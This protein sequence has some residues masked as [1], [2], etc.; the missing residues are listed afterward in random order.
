MNYKIVFNIPN[1]KYPTEVLVSEEQMKNIEPILNDKKVIQIDGN[2]YS[3][4][5][6]AKA[7]KDVEANRIEKSTIPRLEKTTQ[8]TS[9]KEARKKIE[10]LRNKLLPLRFKEE[11]TRFKK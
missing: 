3:T 8:T 6:F 10:E 11:D 5:Y 2:Y 9:D 7:T 1:E 4:S